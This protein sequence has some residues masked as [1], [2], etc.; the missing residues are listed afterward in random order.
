MFHGQANLIEA[1]LDV[2]GDDKHVPGVAHGDAFA[3]VDTQFEVI[4][5]R[6]RGDAPHTLR[7]KARTGT[8]GSAGVQGHAHEGHIVL[9]HLAHILYEGLAQEGVDPPKAGHRATGEQPDATIAYRR[10][11]LHAEFQGPRRALALP[12]VRQSSLGLHGPGPL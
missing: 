9:A 7:P 4:G 1:F 5:A 11:C 2:G 10:R 8:I 6:E 3:Q 12:L